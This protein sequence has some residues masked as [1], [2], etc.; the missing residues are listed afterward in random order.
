MSLPAVIFPDVEKY[1]IDYLRPL[2]AE[3]GPFISN[4]QTSD[5]I[6]AVII[7][8]DGG[9]SGFVQAARRV[10]VRIIND[11]PEQASRLARTVEAL[12]RQADQNLKACPVVDVQTY[13][14]Y[15]VEPDKPGL[16]E[17]YMTAELVVMGS[18]IATK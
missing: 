4:R 11:S 10:G 5:R 12:I 13:G 2:L 7:R 16:T 3:W 8:D 17:F 15:R 6:P 14:P 18:P 9:Q 1:L